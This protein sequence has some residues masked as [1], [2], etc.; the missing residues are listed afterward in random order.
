MLYILNKKFMSSISQLNRKKSFFIFSQKK[1]MTLIN[2]DICLVYYWNTVFHWDVP[3]D[4]EEAKWTLLHSI[5]LLS[6]FN[7]NTLKQNHSSLSSPILCTRIFLKIL[8]NQSIVLF[9]N[10]VLLLIF[11]WKKKY[12]THLNIPL[13]TYF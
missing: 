9:E 7:I 11:F 4:E 6:P 1:I 5:Y 10:A 8:F 12:V 2:I 13:I 3:G